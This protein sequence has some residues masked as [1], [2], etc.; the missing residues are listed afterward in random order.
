MHPW[1]YQF[2]LN[3]T[4]GKQPDSHR[5]CDDPSEKSAVAEEL[6]RN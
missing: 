2:H 6:A 1:N 4:T 3:A 5:F